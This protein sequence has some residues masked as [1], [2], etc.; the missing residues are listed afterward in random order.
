MTT[1]PTLAHALD[2]LSPAARAWADGIVRRTTLSGSLPGLV[3]AVSDGRT[4]ATVGLGTRRGRLLWRLFDHLGI[5][6]VNVRTIKPL[7]M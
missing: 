6:E 2:R 1:E 7:C 4:I 3:R 5:V